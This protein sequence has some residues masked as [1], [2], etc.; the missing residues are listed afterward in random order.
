MATFSITNPTW[1]DL[2]LSSG[3]RYER[4]EANSLSNGVA[5]AECWNIPSAIHH[6]H[7]HHHRRCHHVTGNVNAPHCNFLPK[8]VCFKVET[9]N[10]PGKG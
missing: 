10:Q 7:H 9:H 8:N 2:G 5:Q 3:L 4:P 1:T 6:R